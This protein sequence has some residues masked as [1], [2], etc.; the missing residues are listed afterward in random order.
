RVRIDD[1]QSIAIAL[2]ATLDV[3]IR[4]H[5]GDLGRLVNARHAALH[6]ALALRFVALP[7]WR[8][9]PEVSFSVYGERGVVDGLAWHPGT[10][11]LLVIELKTEFVDINELMGGVDRKRRLAPVIASERGWRPATVSSWVAVADGRTNR[12]ALA[13]HET[14]LRAKF[15]SDGH[16][17]AAWLREPSG[18][19]DALGFLTVAPLAS[20]GVAVGGTR[21]VHRARPVA[22]GRDVR[23]S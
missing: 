15:R 6:E 19:L 23:A 14:T 17:I 21:R 13:R 20:T 3:S 11:S 2:D 4:W 22:P 9:E 8:F 10:R 1:L 7:Q 18:S 16:G 12:R 5:G